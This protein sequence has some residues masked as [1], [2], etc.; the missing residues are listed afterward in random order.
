MAFDFKKEYKEF[1]MPKNKPV[2]VNVPEANYIAV[3][4]EGNPNEEGGAYQ[5]AIGVLYA[6]AYTLR[7]SYKTDYKIEGFFEYVVPPLEGFWWQGEQHPV[8]A[9][10]RT[11]RTDRRENVKGIDYSNKDT[12][13]WISVIRLPDFI[14][15]KDFA[16]AVQTATKKKK[17]DCS[18]AEFLT[19]DEGLCVQIMH[20]GSF[21]SEPATVALLEDYLKEQGYENNINEQRLHHEIYMSDARKVAPEKW[22][23]VIRHP[24]KKVQRQIALSEIRE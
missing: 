16:W 19:I 5:Q 1:Y 4:G 24:I 22:K 15:E 12:F 21:D 23:T 18:P 14:T 8:D 9:E 10:M 6:I 3:R 7:M 2:I 11:D 17:I 20:Q 13:N